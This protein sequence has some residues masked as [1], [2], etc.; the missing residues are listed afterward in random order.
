[1]RNQSANGG[2]SGRRIQPRREIANKGFHRGMPETVEAE[3]IHFFHGLFSRPLLDGHAISGDENAG[4][5]FTEM[6]VHENLVPRL[7]AQ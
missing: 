3:E 6:A 1:M 7:S 5:I 2:Q 4:A